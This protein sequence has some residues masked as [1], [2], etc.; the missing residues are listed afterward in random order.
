[1]ERVSKLTTIFA[2]KH[3]LEADVRNIKTKQEEIDGVFLQIDSVIPILKQVGYAMQI[4]MYE[5]M[6][7]AWQRN[8]DKNSVK[9]LGSSLRKVLDEFQAMD[10]QVAPVGGIPQPRVTEQAAKVVARSNIAYE[11]RKSFMNLINAFNDLMN[12]TDAATS[13]RAI[14]QINSCV[15][16]FPDHVKTLRWFT[17]DKGLKLADGL[18]SFVKLCSPGKVWNQTNAEEASYVIVDLHRIL[19]DLDPVAPIKGEKTKDN[20]QG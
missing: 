20:S 9:M 8:K 1:M 11:L 3:I 4:Q 18:E 10:F 2:Q 19:V 15:R 16:S 7:S 6:R 13:Q 5:D 17:D 14:A 12:P